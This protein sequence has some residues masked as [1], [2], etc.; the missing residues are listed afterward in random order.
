M[1]Q[2]TEEYAE[3]YLPNHDKLFC[4]DYPELISMA[5]AK[6]ASDPHPENFLYHLVM[7]S[8]RAGFMKGYHSAEYDRRKKAQ[9]GKK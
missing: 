4:L 5:K 8:F 6:S 7:L 9:K 3:K 1:Q 2:L